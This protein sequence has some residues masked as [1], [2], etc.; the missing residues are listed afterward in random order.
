MIRKPNISPKKLPRQRRAIATVDALLEAATYILAKQGL[1]GFTANK[2]AE[3]AGVNI[4]S[5]YQYFPNKEALLFHIVQQT[6]ARQLERLAPILARPDPN[7][8]EKLRDFLREFFLTEA[9]EVDLRRALRTAAIDLRETEEFKALLSEGAT[10]IRNFIAEAVGGEAVEDLEFVVDFV[11]LLTTS[12]AERTTDAGTNGTRLI[13]QADVLTGMLVRQFGFT[14]GGSC[15]GS[16]IRL[17]K[18]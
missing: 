5:L 8:A 1:A 9:A 4:A 16:S 10:L 18:G 7:H 6:W 17:Q 3:K 12:F 11:V 14:G 13:Q 2:V 15:P